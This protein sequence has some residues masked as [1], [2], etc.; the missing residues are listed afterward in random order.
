MAVFK[1]RLVE[2]MEI[3]KMRL[4][5]LSNATGI[6][7]GNL[8]NFIHGRYVPKTDKVYLIANALKVNP[9]WLMGYD[10]PMDISFSIPITSDSKVKDEIN[11]K[12]ELLD[13]TQLTALLKIINIMYP[14]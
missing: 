14:D 11:K 12:I 5:D 3:R 8:S 6:H 7:K 4:V 1:D 10:V 13:E 2:A 9:V